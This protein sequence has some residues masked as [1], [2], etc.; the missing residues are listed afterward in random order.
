MSMRA[1]PGRGHRYLRDDSLQ[2]FPFGHGLS[3]TPW[4]YGPPTL[5][6]GGA[7][8]VAALRAGATLN[9]SVVLGNQADAAR[10]IAAIALVRRA[11]SPPEAEAWPKQWL[12]DFE[13]PAVPARGSER[14]GFA[15][16]AAAVSRWDEAAGAFTVRPGRY[17]AWVVGGTEEVTFEVRPRGSVSK[18]DDAKAAA[19]RRGGCSAGGDRRQAWDWRRCAAA[20]GRAR[21]RNLLDLLPAA[22][23]DEQLYSNASLQTW[24]GNMLEG[25]DGLFHLYAASFG[26][27][28]CGLGEWLTNSDVIYATSKSLEGP[29]KYRDTAVPLWAHNPQ[30]IRAPDGNWLLFQMARRNCQADYAWKVPYCNE[31]TATKK[32]C[33][34]RQRPAAA[35]TAGDQA[36]RQHD[37]EALRA[38]RTGGAAGTN[39]VA[40]LK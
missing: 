14:L 19:G 16:G 38:L 28:D 9:F 2:L 31:S 15:V 5:G 33:R 36:R 21:R 10:K 17:A 37:R 3:L 11:D 27:G 39:V 25:D 12:L 13:K 23:F 29:F 8:S 18:T 40:G 7:I 4:S 20:D 26:T 22:T 32:G 24:G 1:Y 35:V 6:G 30:A 34:A